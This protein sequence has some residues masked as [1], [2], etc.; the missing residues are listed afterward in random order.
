MNKEKNKLNTTRKSKEKAH[1]PDDTNTIHSQ[2]EE[3]KNGEVD[4]DNEKKKEKK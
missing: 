2:N 4:T 1:N 3:I